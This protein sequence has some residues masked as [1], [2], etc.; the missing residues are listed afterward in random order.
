[1][2]AAISKAPI[3][4]PWTTVDPLG[5]ALRILRMSGVFY[6]R[7]EFTAPWGL[8]LPAFDQSMMFH[9]VTEGRCWVDVD[10]GDSCILEQGTVA[11][12]PH[13]EGHRLIGEPGA[14]P[15]DLVDAPRELVSPRY[16]LL[17]HGGDGVRTSMVCG[18]VHFDHPAAGDLLRLLPRVI[19]HH[20]ASP[21]LEW[22]DST[23]R[24]VAA[25]AQA[26]EAG[27]EALITRLADI[28]VLDT[29]RSWFAKNPDRAGW[30]GAL[31]DK[32]IGRALNL[33]HRNPNGDWTLGSLASAIGMSRSAFAARF[34]ALVGAPVMHY[35]TRWKMHAAELSLREDRASLGDIADRLGYSSEAAFSRAFKRVTGRS[36]GSIKR[37]DDEST[38][39]L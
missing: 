24:V 25:E 30:L 13:G 2:R 16:E 5:D 22:I 27:G 7:S 6:C 9:V 10:G 20:V 12:I 18:L 4:D 34:T 39:R 14:V 21:Q 28:L 23:L 38:L 11:L 36:P 3:G 26:L 29:V 33:I 35:V 17:R 15:I 1:M 37:A 32:Q 8:A 31:R 19:S